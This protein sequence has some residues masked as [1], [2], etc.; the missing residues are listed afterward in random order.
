MAQT[1]DIAYA[2]HDHFGTYYEYLG[3]SM[4]SVMENTRSALRFHVLCD[5]TLADAARQQLAD[6]CGRYG[7]QISFYDIS[8]DPEIS[9]TELLKSGYNEGILFRLYLPAL[10]PELDRL[11]YLD[12]DIIAHGD[13]AELWA[14]DT[15]E[16]P[17]AGRWD[18]PLYGPKRVD[19]EARRKC[20]AFWNE[21]DW[22]EYINSGV[23]VLNLGKIRK[24]HDM[25]REAVAFWARCGMLFPDQDAVNYIFRGEIFHLPV[26]FNMTNGAVTEAR[27]GV[28]Y[29]Y[30]GVPNWKTRLDEVD[31]IF[32][33]YWEKTPFFKPE[34]GED[35]KLRLM[36]RMKNRLDVYLRLRA[37]GELSDKDT[38]EMANHLLDSGLYAETVELLS[39]LSFGGEKIDL[40]Y[41]RLHLLT[42]ALRQ[43]GKRAAA[44][45][46]INDFLSEEDKLPYFEHD[47]RAT[48]LRKNA[49]IMYCEEKRYAEA[50]CTLE[51]CLYF[52][53]EYKNQIA[54]SALAYLVKAALCMKDVEKAAHYHSLLQSLKPTDKTTMLLGLRLELLEKRREQGV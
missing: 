3:V 27:R 18:P 17:I 15:G 51:K 14:A 2:I 30:T 48:G 45:E 16:Y 25:V 40:E 39:G 37:L 1:I 53:T 23:L 8:L 52:G 22:N 11:I 31:R 33:Y 29:H 43:L 7:C 35:E 44:I 32:L 47:D 46:L 5:A 9:V 12:A 6:I 38:I 50:I 54:V 42:E 13:I 21:T 41:P 34:Y 28:F 20:Q 19:E 4:L 24:E 26:R 36:R 49:G 10:L